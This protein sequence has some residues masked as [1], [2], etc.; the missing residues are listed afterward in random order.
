MHSSTEVPVVVFVVPG[1]QDTQSPYE[2][3]FPAGQEVGLVQ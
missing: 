2:R 1:G 3:Y